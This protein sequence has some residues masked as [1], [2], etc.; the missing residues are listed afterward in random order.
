MHG[1]SSE[2]HNAYQLFL[3]ALLPKSFRETTGKSPTS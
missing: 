3:L 1:T 2:V